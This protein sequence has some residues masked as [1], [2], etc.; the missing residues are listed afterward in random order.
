VQRGDGGWPS[1]TEKGG[2]R[3]SAMNYGYGGIPGLIEKG[4][5]PIL[6]ILTL[7]ERGLQ[8]QLVYPWVLRAVGYTT[9]LGVAFHHRERGLENICN[10]LLEWGANG[11]S[12]HSPF[13]R[14]HGQGVGRFQVGR[15]TSFSQ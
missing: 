12:T 1:A 9:P 15:E 6:M 14:T 2:L 10:K 7:T 4:K 3:I 13:L 5:V 8:R 11:F